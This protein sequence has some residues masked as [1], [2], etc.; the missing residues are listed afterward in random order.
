MNFIGRGEFKV[1][2]ILAMCY[3][4]CCKRAF[5]RLFQFGNFHIQDEF[6]QSQQ[7]IH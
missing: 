3:I 4:R 2:Q 5:M 1:S 7:S 6:L